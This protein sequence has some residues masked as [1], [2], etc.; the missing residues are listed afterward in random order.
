MNTIGFFEI[1]SSN[2]LRDVEF[3]SKVFGWKFT[4]EELF[5]IEYY[6][7]GTDD[8][9]GGLLK[10]PVKVPPMEYGTNAFTCS[11][12]VED[13][14]SIAQKILDLG[15]QIA[16]PKFAVPGRC[17]QGYFIDLDNNTFGIFEVDEDA[18]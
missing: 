17:W 3:Y 8:I 12:L 2:P 6:R 9:Y 5:A 4:K 11:I 14:D 16:L 18:R 7:I 10:R 15:G 1:Q 13:F